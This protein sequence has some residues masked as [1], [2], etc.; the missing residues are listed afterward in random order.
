MKRHVAICGMASLACLSFLHSLSGDQLSSVQPP[1]SIPRA[2]QPDDFT[3]HQD[4]RLVV[5]DTGVKDHS[6]NYVPGL[7]KEA[8]TVSENGKSYP[9]SVFDNNDLPVT[10]GIVVDESQSMTPKRHEVLAAAESLVKASNPRDE[11]FVLNF[12][13]TV[14]AGLP[15]SIPFSS[16]VAQLRNALQRGV[17]QGRTALYDAVLGGLKHLDT[18]KMDR[19]ALVVISDGR[20]TASTHKRFEMFSEIERSGATIYT[21]GL[22]REGDEDA[23]PGILR[24]LAH[25][26]GGEAFFP[27]E[28]HMTSVCQKIAR[29]IRSRYV[30]GYQ[31]PEGKLG[32]LRHVHV[33]VKDPGGHGSL[34][35][36]ARTAYRYGEGTSVTKTQ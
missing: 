3:I 20:D 35:V 18:G 4:V 31:P 17:P 15:P 2:T 29:A 25:M 19:K 1:T 5:L 36:L 34:N 10:L 14:T 24:R 32:D 7:P 27:D 33:S 21:I 28:S 12:N 8:F 11:V 26:S 13:E 22:F 23:D 6:G 30:I 16:N 9:I